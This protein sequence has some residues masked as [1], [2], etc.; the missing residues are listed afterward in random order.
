[1]EVCQL[2][3]NLNVN[4]MMTILSLL[5]HLLSKQMLLKIAA[6]LV[7]NLERRKVTSNKY[8][9]VPEK[10]RKCSKTSLTSCIFVPFYENELWPRH[11]SG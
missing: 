10:I 2:A 11:F 8:Q 5:L 1:M 9:G 3:F 6:T 4:I 7:L